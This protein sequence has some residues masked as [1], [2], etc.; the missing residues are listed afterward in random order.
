MAA[1]GKHHVGVNAAHGY[2][3]G[4]GGG[5]GGARVLENGSK[6]KRARQGSLV[7]GVPAN[8]A[9]AAGGGGGQVQRDRPRAGRGYRGLGVGGQG[10][11]ACFPA[12]FERSSAGPLDPR[13]DSQELE[14]QLC[15]SFFPQ[16]RRKFRYALCYV[17][18]SCLLWAV[19]FGLRQG[20]NWQAHL[21]GAV[22]L[23]VASAAFL[24]LT[25]SPLYGRRYYVVSTMYSLVLCSL[26]LLGLVN[27]LLPP[28]PLPSVAVTAGAGDTGVH[29]R[30]PDMST[31]GSYTGS[32][33][34]LLMIYTL[35]PF[36][37]YLAIAI[38]LAYTCAYEV[39][40]SWAEVH[41]PLVSSSG[42]GGS[43]VGVELTSSGI[44]LTPVRLVAARVLLHVSIHVMGA[45][46]YL[47]T[48]VQRHSAFWQVGQ[49]SVARA[50]LN[51][52]KRAKEEMI[53][54]LMPPM[55]ANAVMKQKETEERDE[56]EDEDDDDEDDRAEDEDGQ[57]AAHRLQ[58]QQQ[59]QQR[60]QQPPNASFM[61]RQFTM[62]LMDNVSILY[63]DIVGF[64]KMSSNK[65]AEHLVKLLNDLF[66]RFDHL[67]TINGCEKISTL[68]DCYYCVSG[69]PN[70]RVDH[71][72]CC[73]EMGLD[74]ITA[75]K[76][77]DEANDE[78]V[79][80]RVGIHTGK[81]LCGI[82]G[83]RRFKF[84]VWSHDVEL[85]NN[86][87]STGMPGR[88]HVSES[89]YAFL[90]K[91][92]YVVEQGEEVEDTR[93][94]KELVENYDPQTM[95][96]RFEHVEEA[97][98]I[99]TYFIDGR[100]GPSRCDAEGG[101]HTQ[102]AGLPATAD[103][104]SSSSGGGHVTAN[105]NLML[106]ATGANADDSSAV[107]KDGYGKS[108]EGETVELV[109]ANDKENDRS[110]L[111]TS[112]FFSRA[113]PGSDHSLDTADDTDVDGLNHQPRVKSKD[114]R[115]QNASSKK[116]D[117]KLVKFIQ[118]DED[119]QLYFYQ[120]P[121]HSITLSFSD[122]SIERKYRL[123]YRKDLMKP[124]AVH[125]WSAPRLYALFDL[126]VAT[127]NFTLITTAVAVVYGAAPLPLAAAP[128]PWIAYPAVMLSLLVA[129]LLV[130][131]CGTFASRR[132]L[133]RP[134]RRAMLGAASWPALQAAGAALSLLPAGLVYA[135]FLASSDQ[136]AASSAVSGQYFFFFALVTALVQF[137][138]YSLL[139]NWLKSCLATATAVVGAVLGGLR[140]FAG[141]GSAA[142]TLPPLAFNGSST[143]SSLLLNGTQWL[144]AQMVTRA[145]TTSSVLPTTLAG[146]NSSIAT[147]VGMAAVRAAVPV[148]PS[149]A[150]ELG[151]DHVLIV[152]FLWLLNR[153]L[154]TLGRLAYYGFLKAQTD[155]RKMRAEKE[156]AEWLLHNI[157][158]RHVPAE[159]VF[160]GQGNFSRSHQNAGVVFASI[161]NFDEMYDE[162]FEGGKEYLRVLNEL[163]NDYEALFEL[164]EY[165]DVEKIKTIGST[166]M[167]ASGLNPACQQNADPKAHLYALM[168]FCLELI[169]VV[170]KFNEGMFNFNFVL[171]IGFNIGDVVSGVIGTTKLHYDIW[172][173]T[174]NVA[175]RMYS[176]GM[177]G[178]IQVPEESKIMLQ[179]AY[180]FEYRGEI[181]VKG[182]G[183]M[184]TWM[185]VGKKHT[186]AAAASSRF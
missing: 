75:I 103:G 111:M 11:S 84:D 20:N 151:I 48:S 156:H 101:S 5:G 109:N 88:V 41:S 58:Q 71:A 38:A 182:K 33:E 78:E 112:A 4:S 113:K 115:R 59:L 158:P 54:S 83:T 43:I 147:D 3:G 174:V 116:R 29:G 162:S 114:P 153:E 110:H 143:A 137:T 74:M 132:R 152:A 72:R 127:L 185:V 165:R 128:S 181:A 73:V 80:M 154:E 90:G 136:M 166:F 39:L 55:V 175:S 2:G 53:H 36:P 94:K 157:I 18:G 17:I 102:P 99:K 28:P 63:A 92:D 104:G 141:T 177:P 44:E 15:A 122:A 30:L 60:R 40:L 142:A 184:R 125:S 180:D 169:E 34:I 64:T 119:S 124:K 87:E 50:E 25:W 183:N 65:T 186:S 51:N 91:D 1:A 121:V 22:L 13:F 149:L 31:V 95:K 79:D 82:V 159:R 131:G 148:P 160:G 57:R 70:P 100:R 108:L 117:I 47:M 120:P 32:V 105:N 62:Y 129:A 37:M 170:Q 35:I 27:D 118:A 172:G 138:N 144:T 42:S 96:Y 16:T 145:A 134:C 163:F 14:A 46:I 133:W 135:A 7:D 167:A 168:D 68:G 164:D 85:A 126:V 77:F 61:F 173:N 69:C 150:F 176:T 52:E 81:V 130:M 97:K 56:D 146:S 155:C 86:M 123:R 89:T 6:D 8:A 139:S 93:R 21:V 49:S 140:L 98:S 171:K 9:A 66:G 178:R 19:N 12:M 67:C 10:G 23:A 24:G 107:A 26:S 76:E 45:Y 106:F 179:D 161:I